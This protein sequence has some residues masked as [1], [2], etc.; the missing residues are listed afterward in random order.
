MADGLEEVPGHTEEKQ[1]FSTKGEV[2]SRP[3]S[4]RL[5]E[6]VGLRDQFEVVTS[7]IPIDG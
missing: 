6:I 5:H 1:T 7:N 2:G 4:N 3:C